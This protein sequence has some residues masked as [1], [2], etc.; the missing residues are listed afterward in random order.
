MRVVICDDSKKEIEYYRKIISESANELGIDLNIKSYT[1]A[2]Q[3][4]F[5]QDDQIAA[6]DVIFLDI[7]MP[8]TSGIEIAENL[9]KNHFNGEIIFVTVSEDHMLKAFDLRAFNYIL[10]Q[11]KNVIREKQI[12]NSVLKVAEDKNKEYIRF[13]GVGEY[14]NIPVS[15][16]KYF[17]VNGKIVSIHYDEKIFE[18]ISTLGKIEN[19]I[20]AKGFIRTHR[21]FIVNKWAIKSISFRELE[22]EDGTL[23]PVGRKYYADIKK[24]LKNFY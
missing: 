12:I 5:E 8:L 1:S 18:I 11:N 24:E 22:L 21:S 10:K 13:T 2:K 16:I 4:F 20:F 9:R 19:I 7:N 17:E 15:R 3:M 6:V 23:L 14:R